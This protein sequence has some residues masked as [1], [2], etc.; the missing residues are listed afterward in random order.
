MSVDRQILQSIVQGVMSTQRRSVRKI[1]EL[2]GSEENDLLVIVWRHSAAV[3][4]H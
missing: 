2:A 4:V 3:H 1:R